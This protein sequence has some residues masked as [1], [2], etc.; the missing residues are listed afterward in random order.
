MQVLAINILQNYFNTLKVHFSVSFQQK[1]V[2][3]ADR[4]QQVLHKMGG[5]CHR[6]TMRR[7]VLTPMGVCTW[8]M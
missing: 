6:V 4:F 7:L 2:R 1:T 5:R 3:N 8:R